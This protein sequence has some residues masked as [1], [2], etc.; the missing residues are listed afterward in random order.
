[1]E[2]NSLSEK[3]AKA[4]QEHEGLTVEPVQVDAPKTEAVHVH[5]RLKVSLIVCADCGKLLGAIS[6]DS[7]KVDSLA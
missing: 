5:K 4:W 6:P 7:E 2:A 3:L 1:V